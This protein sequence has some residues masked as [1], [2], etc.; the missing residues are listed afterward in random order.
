MDNEILGRLFLDADGVLF[1][2]NAGYRAIFGED[3]GGAVG[4][5]DR[6][7]MWERLI[8]RGTFYRDLSPM[9]D[10]F[11]LW[12]FCKPHNP[13]ILTGVPKEMPEADPQKRQAIAEWYGPEVPVITCKSKDKSLHMRPGDYLVDDWEKYANLWRIKGG[14]FIHHRSAAQSIKQLQFFGFTGA[15]A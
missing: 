15:A 3:P 12:N 5:G 13:T 14:V 11:D 2:F 8:A 9:D 6:P 10:S 1:D 4:G 7:D